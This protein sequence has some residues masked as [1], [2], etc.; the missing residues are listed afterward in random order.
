[1]QF[2]D[3]FDTEIAEKKDGRGKAFLYE[4][5]R[6]ELQRKREERNQF[7]LKRQREEAAGKVFPVINKTFNDDMWL[8]WNLRTKVGDPLAPPSSIAELDARVSNLLEKKVQLQEELAGKNWK[9]NN[10]DY[11]NAIGEHWDFTN[12]GKLLAYKM[13]R[14]LIENNNKR[15]NLSKRFK[16]RRYYKCFKRGSESYVR[17]WQKQRE[18]EKKRRKRRAAKAIREA[19]NKVKQSHKNEQKRQR[20]ALKSKKKH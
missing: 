20:I 7:A 10:V 17:E 14:E 2:I 5:H 18:L 16:R 4:L 13:L 3:P 15:E 1:M 8:P 19:E 11:G 9:N 12:N 6:F